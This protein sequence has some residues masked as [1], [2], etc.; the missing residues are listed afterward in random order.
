MDIKCTFEKPPLSIEEQLDLL[1]SRGL[2]IKDR[3]LASHYLQFI[4]YYRFS[5][6]ASQPTQ[7]AVSNQYT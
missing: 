5:G 2:I 7:M 6:Y 3:K 4:S 1:T